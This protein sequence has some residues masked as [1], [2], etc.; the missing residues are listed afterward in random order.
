MFTRARSTL[1]DTK[2]N[3]AECMTLLRA[4]GLFAEADEHMLAE[5]A[6]LLTRV[7]YRAGEVARERAL[8]MQLLELTIQ[9]DDA[10]KQHDIDQIVVSERFQ[11]A[12]ELARRRR[13]ERNRDN[14]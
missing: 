4:V 14:E 6:G 2:P 13:E 5:L 12:A 11:R 9:I 1:P 7:H 3:L 10:T 8:K